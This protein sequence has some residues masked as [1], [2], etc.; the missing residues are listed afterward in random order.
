[1]RTKNLTNSL[2]APALQWLKLPLVFLLTCLQLTACGGGSSAPPIESIGST[3]QL[4]GVVEDGPIADA[5]VYLVHKANDE[6]VDACGPQGNQRCESRSNAEGV[7]AFDTRPGFVA[8]NYFAVAIGGR[9]VT[10]GV[11]FTSLEMRAPL[12]LATD[13]GEAAVISPVTTLL[14][15]LLDA[16]LDLNSAQEQLRIWLA[17]APGH[18]LGRRPSEDAELLR[19]SLLLTKLAIELQQAGTTNPFRQLRDRIHQSAPLLLDAAR[20]N[21]VTLQQLGLE[22]AA[23]S[24][25]AQ[26]FQLLA[27]S[28][29]EAWNQ[30]FQREEMVQALDLAARAMLADAS[31]FDPTDPNLAANLQYLAEQVLQAAGPTGIPFGGLAPQRLARY[32]LLNYNLRSLEALSNPAELFA[33]GL[34]LADG[35][36]LNRDP[37]VKELAQSRTLY[38]VAAPLLESERPG[39]DNQRRL[40][41]YYNSDRS[42]L[43]Q[44]ERLLATVLDDAVSDTVLLSILGGKAEAG[45]FEDAHTLLTTQIFGSENRGKGYRAYAAALLKFGYPDAAIEAL[46]QARIL[47]NRVIAAKGNASASSS[48]TYN[49]QGLAADFRKAGDLASAQLVLNDLELVARD[50]TSL[51]AHGRLVVGTWQVADF[52][53]DNGDLAAAAPILESLYRFARATPPN[54]SGSIFTLRSRVFYLIETARRFA[55]LGDYPRALAIAD[56]IEAL[57]AFDGYSNLTGAETWVPGWI[58]TLVLVRYQAGDAAGA[59]RLAESIPLSYKDAA[60]ATK[61]GEAVRLSAFK[62]V[63]TYDALNGNLAQAF[64][65]VDSVF[66]KPEDRVDALTYFASN[67]GVPYIGLGLIQKSLLADAAKAL[68]RAQAAL[69]TVVASSDQNRYTLLIQRGWVKLADLYALMGDTMTARALLQQAETILPA[70]TAALPQVNSLRDIALSYHQRGFSADATRLLTAA[71]SLTALS[72]SLK[73]EETASLYD[74]IIQ[75]WLQTGEPGRARLLIGEVP[76]IET[77]PVWGPAT[78]QALRIHDPTLVYTGTAHDD[79][80]GKEVDA[81]LKLATQ[82]VECS[83]PRSARALLAEAQTTADRMFVA[84]TRI[85]KY[86][87]SSKA[88]IIGGYAKAEG[89]DQALT[90]ARGLAFANNRSQAIQYLADVYAS[91]D[92]FPDHWVA[93]IDSDRDGRP[94]FFSP[95]ATTADIA[96][97]GLILDDDSDGDGIADPLDW[98]PLFPDR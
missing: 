3:T 66:A 6:V 20:L 4:S 81:L 24:R 1:M 56:E 89:F 54:Q 21:E 51:S 25:A 86:I 75:A 17:L 33:A 64:A 22:N 35:T 37:L 98:R 94:D 53:I 26:L 73:P 11:D 79:Q 92:D 77:I 38:S 16:G 82:L 62:Q 60:G 69:A 40:E 43:H 85:G 47:F 10:T 59:L 28:Q 55:D 45:L 27:A 13:R 95:L 65:R 18:D 9:D 34:L 88:H 84:A 36:P 50:L 97:S 5:L 57:R 23:V 61:S 2:S 68:A 71:E 83:Y 7:F 41:Y 87:H 91:Q 78:I 30:L 58:T 8:S 93:T 67:K 90:L 46:Q 39:N 42:H 29:P 76:A 15:G 31:G 80:A 48:D 72:T 52:Y 70:I 32:V 44:A 63:A 49:L 19:R 96:A 74:V 12:E 14:A